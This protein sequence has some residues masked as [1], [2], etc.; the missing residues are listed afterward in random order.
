MGSSSRSK[1][2]KKILGG[3]IQEGTVNLYVRM[4]HEDERPDGGG[5]G[6]GGG[7]GKGRK[8]R[9]LLKDVLGI[10]MQHTTYT[11]M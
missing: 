1:N 4:K 7:R 3:R 6:G 8:E 9:R 10:N 11:W 5:G 2:R